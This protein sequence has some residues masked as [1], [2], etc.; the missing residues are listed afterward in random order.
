MSA[1]TD[2]AKLS[3]LP[4]AE[5]QAYL[6]KRDKL[7]TTYAWQDMWQDEH[8]TQ[9][10]V[11]RLT[12]L[13]LL[14]ALRD[15]ITKSVDGDLSRRDW[16]KDSEKLLKDAGWWG[17]KAVTDPATGEIVFTKFDSAR[18][19]LI[20][21]TNTRQAYAAGL[22]E[23]IERNKKTHPYVRYITQSDERVRA[24][25][26]AWN[27]VTLPVDDAFWQTHWPP[28]GWRCRCRVT[29]MNQR[30]YDKGQTPTGAP[31]KTD[32]PP[33]ETREY[34]NQRS[35]EI[36][37]VPQGIDPGF[38]YNA[39]QARRK[40]LQTVVSDKLNTTAPDLAKAQIADLTRSPA[41][42]AWLDH[43]VGNWPLAV[44]PQMDAV[45]IGAKQ[46]IAVLS[47]QTAEKQL[48]R[49]PDLTDVEY[50]NAQRVIDF[51]TA[52]VADAPSSMIYVLEDLSPTVG[53]YVLVVK[54]TRSGEGL[55][56]TSYRRLSR[57]EAKRDSEIAR[58]LR[59][60]EKK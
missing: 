15:G 2:F 21:D 5:A 38:G 51:A 54:A 7:T 18:L 9:F 47:S 37:Q 23:R 59:K 13:D 49:H 3:S 56:I 33:V 39:G 45:A 28:N 25:H 34:V 31:L 10:T 17:T 60:E 32:P 8:A 29:S 30:E 26:R 50:A 42:R 20:Y 22:W 43:P 27:G 35:G 4:P 16:M 55:F 36:S 1:A 41:F 52:K 48:R 6:A 53:G 44:L 11:S 46:S 24:S 12:R 57:D 19:K 14:Q 40:Q 58:L